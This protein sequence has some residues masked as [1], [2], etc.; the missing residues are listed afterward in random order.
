MLVGTKDSRREELEAKTVQLYELEM[1][2]DINAKDHLNK[3][4]KYVIELLDIDIKIDYEGKVIILMSF[5][6]KSYEI[7]V[8]TLLVEKFTMIILTS[9]SESGNIKNTSVNSSQV[10]QVK[11]GTKHNRGDLC[12]KMEERSQSRFM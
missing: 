2:Q 1:D 9:L 4:N 3:F 8:S 11:S 5:L 6:P 7:L 10:L 12:G